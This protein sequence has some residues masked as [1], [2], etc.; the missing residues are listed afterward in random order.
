MIEE[1]IK[2]YLFRNGIPLPCYFLNNIYINSNMIWKNRNSQLIDYPAYNGD[3]A[4]QI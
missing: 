2:G 4:E 1:L 3:F